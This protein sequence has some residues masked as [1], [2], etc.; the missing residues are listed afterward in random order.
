MVAV[1]LDRRLAARVDPSDIVQDTMAEADRLLSSYAR[2]RPI[3]FYPWLRQIAAD[4][5]ADA[6][7]RHLQAR[8]RSVHREEPAG[9]PEESA[10]E[11]AERLMAGASPSAGL[12]REERRA[13]VRAALEDLA[14]PDREI[15]VLRYLEQ[16]STQEAAAVLEINE[17]AVK[18]RLLRA[19]G[20]L[21]EVM[22][23]RESQP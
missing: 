1:R 2:D 10:A 22:N 9:L 12:R 11:L 15:L 3:P 5:V 16:L 13:R 7:R 18:M 4:R 21:R 19:L 14:S 6:H 8:K 23:S 17:G 20:R